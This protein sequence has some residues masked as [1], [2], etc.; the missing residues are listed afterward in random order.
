MLNKIS[1]FLNIKNLLI[2]IDILKPTPTA[3]QVK[4]QLVH[5][6]TYIYIFSQVK[7]NEQ[8]NRVEIYEKTVEVLGPQVQK[9]MNF[10][11]FQVITNLYI[12][13]NA[14]LKDF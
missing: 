3:N 12:C 4:R 11:Y 9:L 5:L 13:G 7:S 14:S 2:L 6:Y 8:P 10:M 1:V